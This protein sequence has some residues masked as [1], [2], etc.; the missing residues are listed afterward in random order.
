MNDFNSRT[1]EMTS[2][3]DVYML[4]NELHGLDLRGTVRALRRLKSNSPETFQRLV[5][6]SRWHSVLHLPLMA[7]RLRELVPRQVTLDIFPLRREGS[8]SEGGKVATSRT[9]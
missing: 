1:A 3:M 2:D 8:Q 5:A 7:M 4:V 6:Y 9:V